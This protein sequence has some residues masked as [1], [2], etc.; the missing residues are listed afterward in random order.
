MYCFPYIQRLLLSG[1]YFNLLI[2]IIKIVSTLKKEGIVLKLRKFLVSVL[3]L[4]FIFMYAQPSFANELKSNKA[5]SGTIDLNDPNTKF[6]EVLTFD[7]IVKEIAVDQGISENQAA[8]QLMSSQ[9]SKI[10]ESAI[11]P[12]GTSSVST[13]AATYRTI[14]QSFTVTS[15][16][17]PSVKFYTQTSEGGGYWG[18]VTIL[19][20]GMNRSYNGISK[21]FGGTVYSNL[22]T[23]ARIFY[24]VN[25]D[26][27]NNGTTTVSGGGE[28]AVGVG[29][30]ATV[31]FNLSYSSNF[32]KYCYVEGRIYTQ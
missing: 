26:F 16:Y 30:S 12:L 21:Q 31:N 1:H 6:S 29:A 4:G 22:E 20:V 19:N 9:N 11:S 3:A 23:A 15:I 7:E 17:K 24:I 28:V 5:T 8:N 25:G 10:L 2:L 32:Y 18:I 13:L 27:F 14:T